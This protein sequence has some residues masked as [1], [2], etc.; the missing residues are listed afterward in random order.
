MSTRGIRCSIHDNNKTMTK[1]IH[2]NSM[3]GQKGVNLIEKIVL[4]MGFVWYPT[5]G[6]EAGIDGTIEIR[7]PQTGEVANNIIQ[8]Q[9]K[10]TEIPFVA[11][12]PDKF[13]YICKDKDIEY[14]LGGNTPVILIV[15]RPNDSLIYWVS[16]KDYFNSPEKIKSKKV[17]FDKKTNAFSKESASDLINFAV[18]KSVGLYLDP[19]QKTEVMYSNLLEIKKFPEYIYMADTTFK[20]GKEIVDELRRLGAEINYEWILRNKRILSFHDL[21]QYPWNKL[22]DIGTLENF[23][24]EEW[25]FADD[26]DRENELRDLLAQS[27]SEMLK[28]K[29]IRYSKDNKLY[30]FT[31]TKKLTE[32]RIKY[33]SIFKETSR[34]VFTGYSKRKD[35]DEPAYY[36]HSAFEGKFLKFGDKWYLEITPTYYFTRDGYEEYRFAEEKIKKIKMLE[37]NMAILGQVIMW[38]KILQPAPI[39]NLFDKT[40]VD[41]IE[42]GDL[43]KIESLFGIDDKT[44]LPKEEA[45]DIPSTDYEQLLLLDS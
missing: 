40:K 35:S 32:R 11:E 38:A 23:G 6:L 4:E 29:N 30:H 15:S 34:T 17:Y 16:V 24:V 28:D 1:K 19:V 22:C 8:V 20:R 39:A 36:R 44:W 21:D 14:W 2:N 31:A 5:G 43:L 3:T 27:L 7:N 42:F 41:H 37:L 25:A 18:S 33:P 13:E 45:E 12:T 9:S 10:A 26:R